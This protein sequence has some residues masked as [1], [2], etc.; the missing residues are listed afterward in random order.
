MAKYICA[1]VIWSRVSLCMWTNAEWINKL[2]VYRET[3]R[4]T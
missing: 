2:A 1:D 4:C 3:D